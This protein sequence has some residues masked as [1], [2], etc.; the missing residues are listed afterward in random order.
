MSLL[1]LSALG[2]LLVGGPVA[3]DD[4][5]G[6]T[7][8]PPGAEIDD[9]Q[10]ADI[11]VTGRAAKLYRVDETVSGKLPTEPLASSQAI[12]VI[13]EQL[14]RDQGARDAQ[15]LYRNISG[16]SV[17]SYAGV[18]A[19]GF[20]QQ[21][22]FYD[23]L[24]GDPYIGFSVPQLFN[25]ARVEFLKGPAGMLYGQT[26]P[27]GLFNYVTKKPTEQFAAS[28]SLVAGD[29]NRFGGQVEASGPIAPMLSARLGG[30]H[31]RRDLPRTFADS[32]TTI[33]DGGLRARLI[34]R[35]WRYGVS[36][37]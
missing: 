16:V 19:R 11:V 17:F 26:A 23:G 29:Y 33:L 30:F 7:L 22:N 35:A 5:Q 21:E 27:G 20:R 3:A 10:V 6:P 25:I 24:R 1:S 34:I 28:A 4:L 12:T 8:A 31:E 15:D 2:V 14:I 36:F 37:A 9:T 32:K 18:T 13:T